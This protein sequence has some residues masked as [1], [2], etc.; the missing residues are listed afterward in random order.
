VLVKNEKCGASTKI[1]WLNTI[2]HVRCSKECC[3][4]LNTTHT[5]RPEAWNWNCMCHRSI[6]NNTERLTV[7][8]TLLSTMNCRWWW[9][10]WTFVTL[11]WKY[12]DSVSLYVN[13]EHW[14]CVF[15]TLLLLYTRTAS[16]Q[17]TSD[18]Y[19]LLRIILAD[20]PKLTQGLHQIY[21]S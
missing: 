3:L 5:A 18:C 16:N 21:E 15:R 19:Q 14:K 9:T 4:H 11:M 6:S 17:T 2:F 8:G 1:T 10:F 20:R 13:Y 12:N 7:C